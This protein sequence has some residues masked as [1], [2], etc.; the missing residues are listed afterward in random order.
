MVAASV[1]VVC[2]SSGLLLRDTCPLCDGQPGWPECSEADS[3]PTLLDS[4]SC[5]DGT[6]F[7]APTPRHQRH[8]TCPDVDHERG[9]VKKSRYE[10]R[11]MDCSKAELLS[12]VRWSN[13]NDKLCYSSGTAVSY[14]YSALRCGDSILAAS[15][16]FDWEALCSGGL[17]GA[18]AWLTD[19]VLA[20][21]FSDMS[22]S[23]MPYI[24]GETSSARAAKDWLGGNCVA[25]AEFLLQK[26]KEL[27]TDL[28]AFMVPSTLPEAY[29]QPGYPHFGHVT[30]AIPLANFGCIILDPAIRL[31]R[32]IMLLEDGAEQS[33]DWAEGPPAMNRKKVKSTTWRFLLDS[34]SGQVKAFSPQQPDI[35]IFTYFLK[36][37]RNADVAITVPTNDFNKRILIVRT[38]KDGAKS[39]HLSIRIDKERVEA[40]VNETWK[41][42]LP[43]A[44]LAVD[45]MAKLEAWMPLAEAREFAASEGMVLDFYQQILQI[46]DAH[47]RA[48]R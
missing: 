21:C 32:P 42:P 7:D 44:E 43:F 31:N 11:S 29:H 12:M 47:G 37:V 10:R 33:F 8:F 15:P 39:S 23:R 13:E 35:P 18:E 25:F 9:A 26:L 36:P 38:K 27:A 4:S 2:E 45:A 41:E 14:E 34:K 3:L 19:Q 1:C 48:E 40:F 46:V 28:P 24:F 5:Y 20:P 16:E 30:V 22:Y 6:K 17:D